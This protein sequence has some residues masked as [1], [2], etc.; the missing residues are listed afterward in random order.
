MIVSVQ[1]FDSIL[2]YF[3]HSFIRKLLIF[4]KRQQKTKFYSYLMLRVE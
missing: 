4:F 1:Y 2:L 3:I